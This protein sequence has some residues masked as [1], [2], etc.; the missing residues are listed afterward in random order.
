MSII[1]ELS[2]P[3]KRAIDLVSPV[4]TAAAAGA[5][6][7]TLSDVALTVTIVAGLLSILWYAVRLHDRFRHGPGR[8]E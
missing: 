8:G 6:A 5:A 3:T 2:E 7:W 4:A 1:A